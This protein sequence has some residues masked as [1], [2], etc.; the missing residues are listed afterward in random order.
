MFCF[1]APE[2]LHEASWRKAYL[3]ASGKGRFR[4]FSAGS[5]PTGKVNPYALELL[6]KS[7]LPTAGAQEQGMG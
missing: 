2:I 3:N 4:T 1:C 7:H 5:H 6:E